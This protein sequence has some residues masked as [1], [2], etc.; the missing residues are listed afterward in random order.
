MNGILL[1]VFSTFMYIDQTIYHSATFFHSIVFSRFLHANIDISL[2]PF[3]C[4]IISY[5]INMPHF[6]ILSPVDEY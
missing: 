5:Y 2:V 6:I 3:I 1:C 4:G